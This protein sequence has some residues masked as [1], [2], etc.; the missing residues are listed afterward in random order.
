[1]NAKYIVRS[2]NLYLKLTAEFTQDARLCTV[3]DEPSQARTQAI[4]FG[5]DEVVRV[6]LGNMRE[7]V[8]C[9]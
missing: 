3:F 5:G 7:E 9:G 8:I 6:I 1:V 2:G 4:E